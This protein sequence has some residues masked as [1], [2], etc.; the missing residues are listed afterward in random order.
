MR[1]LLDRCWLPSSALTRDAQCGADDWTGLDSARP[2]QRPRPGSLQQPPPILR[3]R[4]HEGENASR[5][6]TQNR[7]GT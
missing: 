6:Y 4:L 7:K 3:L 1:I 2:T 5:A